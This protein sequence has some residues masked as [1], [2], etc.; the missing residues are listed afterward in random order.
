MAEVIALL[1]EERAAMHDHCAMVCSKMK[2]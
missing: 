1:L 2:K